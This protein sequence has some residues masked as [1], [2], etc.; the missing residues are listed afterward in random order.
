MMWIKNYRIKKTKKIINNL[1]NSMFESTAIKLLSSLPLV[2]RVAKGQNLYDNYIVEL[3][4]K[5]REL[6]VFE[7]KE[8]KEVDLEAANYI[9][10]LLEV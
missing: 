7:H 6:I 3:E 5:N 4:L 8:S 2:I 10:K 9:L 1:Q